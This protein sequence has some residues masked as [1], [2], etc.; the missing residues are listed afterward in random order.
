[1]QLPPASAAAPE[2][3][4]NSAGIA[5]QPSGSSFNNSSAMLS[6]DPIMVKPFTIN[7]PNLGGNT[8]T[9]NNNVQSTP[10]SSNVYQNQGGTSQVVSSFEALNPNATG[11][12]NKQA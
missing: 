8:A 10:L 3:P 9:N 5:K 4:I 12:S 6:G 11:A 1:M 7:T 2:D